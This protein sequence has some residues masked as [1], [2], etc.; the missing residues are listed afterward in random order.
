ME[1]ESTQLGTSHNCQVRAR[2]QDQSHSSYVGFLFR[3]YSNPDP[4]KIT[5]QCCL[6]A[7]EDGAP[8]ARTR[9]RPGIAAGTGPEMLKCPSLPGPGPERR[10]PSPLMRSPFGAGSKAGIVYASQ[11]TT[12][13]G[14]VAFLVA[15]VVVSSERHGVASSREHWRKQQYLGGESLAPLRSGCTPQGNFAGIPGRVRSRRIPVVV[16]QT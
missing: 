15:K 11:W 6:T 5:I 9:G 14:G 12:R 2:A 7:D 10:P 8:S 13:L 4:Q 16:V 3:C 1:T